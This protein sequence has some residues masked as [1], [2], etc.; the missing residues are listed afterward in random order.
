MAN[1]GKNTN[2]SQFFITT[3]VTHWLDNKHV[4]FGRVVSGIDVV[5]A[6]ERCGQESGKVTRPCVVKNCGEL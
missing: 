5:K 1:A 4:V 6:V 3:N 2:G